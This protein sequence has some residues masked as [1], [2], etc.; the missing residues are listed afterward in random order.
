MGL[1][2]GG[3]YNVTSKGFDIVYDLYKEGYKITKDEMEFSLESIMVDT[4]K[5]IQMMIL[6]L[7]YHLQKVG[8]DKMKEEIKNI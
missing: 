1:I 4:P 6:D 7:V 2:T 3:K 8:I 5:K